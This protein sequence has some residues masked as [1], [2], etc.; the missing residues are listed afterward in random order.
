MMI[1]DV[2][3]GRLTI[4]AVAC[5]ALL[6]IGAPQAVADPET[7]GQGFVNSTARCS[8]P[9]I[10]VAF[11]STDDARV[12]ICKTP[13]GQLEYRGVRVEDGAKL[14]APASQTTDGAFVAEDD[15]K[16][17]TVTSSA[18][19]VSRG[20]EVISKESMINFYQPGTGGAS[21]E[22]SAPAS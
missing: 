2:A 20:Q 17:Y 8:P 7:D 5:S 13:S 6:T 9:E 3:I 4:A 12:A 15:G 14:I 11:G 18:L 16:I 22:K 10:A 19:V 21:R 1:P